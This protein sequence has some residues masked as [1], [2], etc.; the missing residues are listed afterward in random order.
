MGMMHPR[1][2]IL[3]TRTDRIGDL[4]LSTPVFRALREAFPDAFI[5]ALVAEENR[6]LAEGQSALDDVL[7]LDKRGRHK[8]W[9]GVR[10]LAREIQAMRFDCAVH[11]HPTARVHW[12]TVLARIPVRIGYASKM[13]RLTL[14][15]ALPERKRRG[16]DHEARYNFD[17]LRPLGVSAPETFSLEVPLREDARLR[18]ERELAGA[19]NGTAYAVYHPGASCPSKRWPAERFARVADRVAARYGF[20]PVVIGDRLSALHASHMQAGMQ[21]RALNLAGRLDLAMTAWLL[22]RASLLVSNDSGPVHMAAAFD[23]P[24]VA[25]F[26]RTRPGLTWTRWGPL[27]RASRVAHQDVGCITCLAHRCQIGFLCLQALSV[28]Q[29]LSQVEA[30]APEFQHADESELSRR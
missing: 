13:G 20:F 9:Q 3:V 27:N 15:R 21:T 6:L 8:S 17:L 2:R 25:I 30:L 29:V 26:G 11:L 5:A 1:A 23:R 19:L 7:L 12:L 22:A 18:L 24:V 28:E 4:V 16:E 14:T 10:A